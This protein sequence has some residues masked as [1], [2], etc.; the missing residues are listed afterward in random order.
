MSIDYKNKLQIIHGEWPA[1]AVLTSKILKARGFSDQ[2]IQKYCHSGW[3]RRVGAG[4][5]VRQ[6]D[7]ILWQGGVYAMQSQLK[8]SIHIGGL[9]A[10][11]LRGL[12][13]YLELSLEKNIYLYN[14]SSKKSQ[15]PGWFT[16]AFNKSLHIVYKQ[17]HI[18]E[19]EIGLVEQPI[20]GL[21]LVIS[22][23][24]RAILE[25][26]YFVPTL[27]SVEHAAHLV[28]NLQTIRPEKMQALLESCRHILVKRLF[29]CLADLCQLPVL[30]HLD[31]NNV[32][33]G[34]GDRTVSPGGKYFSQYQL[35]LDYGS[36]NN[37]RE[38]I[39]V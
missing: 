6:Q 22:E 29:L 16:S 21:E 38:E 15:L 11:E 1:N 31:Q 10:L 8:K 27:I 12:S 23:P 33:L 13:H 35:I 39:N 34:S 3:L 18:F 24:E 26:L 32:E 25:L 36:H 5:F 20:E 2:L 9:T 14:T 28:E 17:C 7:K 30:K 4:A 19:N 37:E